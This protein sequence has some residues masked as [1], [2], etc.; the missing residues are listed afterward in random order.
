MAGKEMNCTVLSAKSGM[1]RQLLS[2]KQVGKTSQLP[3]S[4]YRVWA[5]SRDF[6]ILF[7]YFSFHWVTV[8]VRYHPSQNKKSHTRTT[9]GND[10]IIK[11]RN[12]PPTAPVPQKGLWLSSHH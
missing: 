10:L 12:W 4:S 3:Q 6:S 1:G 8:S 2:M 9:P 11:N 5:W 7:I